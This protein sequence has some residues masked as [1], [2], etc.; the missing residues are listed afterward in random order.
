MKYI[1]LP[2]SVNICNISI[3]C[4]EIFHKNKMKYLPSSY[5]KWKNPKS[6]VRLTSLVVLNIKETTINCRLKIKKE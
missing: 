3:K 5:K 6:T 1:Y 2:I 4:N